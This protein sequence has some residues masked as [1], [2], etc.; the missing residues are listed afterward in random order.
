MSD[1]L[2]SPVQ[3]GMFGFDSHD[4]APATTVADGAA[5]VRMGHATVSETPTEQSNEEQSYYQE[6]QGHQ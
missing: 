2:N 1:I 5:T 4:E 3:G 6:E